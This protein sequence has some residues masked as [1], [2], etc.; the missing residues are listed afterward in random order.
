MPV[1]AIPLGR[2]S[3]PDRSNDQ[4][5]ARLINCYADDVGEEGKFRYPIY[6][7]D[8]YSSFS[9]LG[10][11]SLRIR[12]LF[13]FNET[14]M[15]VVCG[16]T[17]YYVNSVGGSVS[18]GTMP[19]FG[20]VYFARNRNIS[21][22]TLMVENGT[23]RAIVNGNVT[24][25]SLDGSI[26]P[27]N[28]VASVNGYFVITSSIGEFFASDLDAITVDPLS[29]AKASA[30]PDGLLRVVQR[31]TDAV[32]FGQR[33][34]E[35]WTENGNID[36]PFSRVQVGNFGIWSA[37]TAVPVSAVVDGATIDTIAFAATNADGAFIGVCMLTGYEAR[38]ISPP[39]LDR[40]IL[41]ELS[42]DQIKGF[43]H[44][45][46][47]V[48]FYTISG[49]NFTW[50]LNCRT[51]LWHERKSNGSSRW[52][53]N[54]AVTFNG[55]TIYADYISNKLYEAKSDISPS[56]NNSVFVRQSL[57]GGRTWG[58]QRNKFI[59]LAGGERTRTRFNRWGMAREDGRVLEVSMDYALMELTEAT[60]MIIVTPSLHSFPSRTTLHTV[61][62]DMTS[63]ASMTTR[64]KGVLGLAVDMDGKLA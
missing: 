45:R 32:L 16:T 6:A 11:T 20:P 8:G 38:K 41:A 55:R 46:G 52:R 61:F 57:D 7:C 17:A 64:A 9:T 49:A 56:G 10:A 13:T 43:T 18:M 63:G 26:P 4:G 62:V 42:P 33:S 60:P 27:L 35:F 28:S 44:T 14:L 59:G 54:D 40:A 39:A 36:F 2:Q 30:C 15:Y 29:F 51:G 1:T 25:V 3:N 48:T 37:P 22:Q 53:V 58:A 19:G 23:I 12:G 21:E 5:A 50:E 31:G 47:G 24:T 34:T